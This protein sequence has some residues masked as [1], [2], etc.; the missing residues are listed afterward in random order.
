[1]QAWWLL[2]I[3]KFIYYC[4][5]IFACI[6]STVCTK[7]WLPVFC[8]CGVCDDDDFRRND[9]W[10][11]RS[12][13]QIKKELTRKRVFR[14][15]LPGSTIIICNAKSIVSMNIVRASCILNVTR[16]NMYTIC[17]LLC[18]INFLFC[19]CNGKYFVFF[20]SI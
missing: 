12:K 2:L 9:F 17:I 11:W 20:M 3:L 5:H 13:M 15:E 10:D 1:M 7:T 4:R 19:E 6:Y 8:F 18:C 16:K 14:F